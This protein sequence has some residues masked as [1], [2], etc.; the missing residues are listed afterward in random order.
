MDDKTIFKFCLF[1]LFSFNLLVSVSC[2]DSK[3]V[4]K[5]PTDPP[6]PPE[7]RI[8]FVVDVRSNSPTSVTNPGF[9][10][11]QLPDLPLAVSLYQGLLPSSGCSDPYLIL[12][13][14]VSVDA[15]TSEVTMNPSLNLLENRVYKFFSKIE[16]EGIS[17][18][19]IEL[20]YIIDTIAPRIVADTD[21]GTDPMANDDIPRMSKTWTWSCVDRDGTSCEY[22][23]KI[24]DTPL[25]SGTSCETHVFSSGD[26]YSNTATATKTG[27]DGKHCIHIQ[28]KDEAGNQSTVVSVYATLDNTPSV[29]SEV[30]IPSKTY[31]GGDRMDFTVTFNEPITVTGGPRIPL[32]LDGGVSSQTRYAEYYQGSGSTSLI[33]RYQV[34]PEDSDSDG[35]AMADS[36]DLNSGTLVDEAGNGATLTI[37]DGNKPDNLFNVLV[38]G[39]DPNVILSLTNLS[40]DENGGTGTYTVKLNSQPTGTVTV[41][42]GSSD[43]DVVTVTPASLSFEAD[44][45]NG[46]LWSNPQT[47]TITGVNNNI[48]DDAGGGSSRTANVTHTVTSTDTDYGGLTVSPVNVTSVDDDDIGS[49]Q[50]TVTPTRV[51]EHDESSS[52]TQAN[53]TETIT[54]TAEFQGGTS[55]DVRLPGDLSITTSVKAGTAQTED[56]TAVSDFD[57]SIPAGNNQAEG[58]FDLRVVDDLVDEDEETLLVRGSTSLGLVVNPATITLVDND[59]K[60]VTISETSLVVYEDGGTGTYDVQLETQPTGPVTIH[61]ASS[62]ASVVTVSPTLLTF[63]PDDSN[64]QIWS[65]P[66]TVTIT[67]VDD[68]I[69]NDAGNNFLRTANITHNVI[70]VDTVYHAINVASVNVTSQDDEGLPESPVTF[71]QSSL[72]V[73]EGDQVTYTVKLESEPT[74]AP[75]VTVEL[76][77]DDTSTANV[78]PSTL[79]FEADDTNGKLWSNP[80][81]VTVT[82]VTD[83]TSTNNRQTTIANQ[84]TGKSPKN[85]PITVFHNLVSISEPDGDGSDLPDDNTTRG[86]VTV[87]GS[88]TGDI[89]TFED[90]DWFKVYFKSGRVYRIFLIGDYTGHDDGSSRYPVGGTLDEPYLRIYDPDSTLVDAKEGLYNSSVLDFVPDS[91]GVYYLSAGSLQSVDDDYTGTYTL[92]VEDRVNPLKVQFESNTYSVTEGGGLQVKL[93]LDREPGLGL[94]I[95]IVIINVDTDDSDYTVFNYNNSVYFLY[96]ETLSEEEPFNI[97]VIDDSVTEG[98]E[99]LRL[100]FGPLPAGVIAGSQNTATV[101]ITDQ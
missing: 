28:A 33:F 70:S 67:G 64:N 95:P 48:D 27:G 73:H 10:I 12:L 15:S 22:R 69:D 32:T 35:I 85:L 75:S 57:I 62:D 56:F 101:T 26:P 18:V 78:S 90:K 72:S 19:C 1:I 98:S 77:S 2:S 11:K 5:L 100:S 47:V 20:K 34:I 91:D 97:T 65:N 59:E 43:T 17:N 25:S 61:I 93:T 6:E 7:T 53:N 51:N 40:V 31:A 44:N 68:N 88:A 3:P 36:I 79:T 13:D 23:Y 82:G 24:D 21:T 58:T 41:T 37:T 96:D 74:A 30:S 89:S 39:S 52:N 87:G 38:S 29:I 92:S 60:G 71:S 84:I 86:Q 99:T 42:L 4:A 76:T 83:S 46:K 50:L 80:Q 8:I 54:V 9:I 45:S 16:G 14:S 63:D 49:I 66:Q 55:A 81:T 94:I